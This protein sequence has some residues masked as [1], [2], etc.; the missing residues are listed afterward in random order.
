MQTPELSEIPRKMG[1]TQTKK[2]KKLELIEANMQPK[3]YKLKYLIILTAALLFT[4][5]PV[6]N[7]VLNP[8]L[9]LFYLAGNINRGRKSFLLVPVVIIV[10][11]QFRLG[12]PI[13]GSWLFFTITG[14]SAVLSIGMLSKRYSLHFIS[15]A[16]I[17]SIGYWLW[18]NLGTWMLYPNTYPS[19]LDC[20]ISAI[21]FLK[22]SLMGSLFWATVFYLFARERTREPYIIDKIT[23]AIP[24]S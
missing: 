8:T 19:L 10:F 23:I 14:Y 7:L 4:S 13:I 22:S 12:F 9:F 1:N 17:S 18:T 3:P 2:M 5:D 24:N 15:M 21:P 6:F 16:F 11:T 20:Y